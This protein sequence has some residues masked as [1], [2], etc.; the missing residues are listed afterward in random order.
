MIK[1]LNL[2]I[3]YIRLTY[4]IGSQ[5]DLANILGVKLSR[6][7]SIE[8]GKVKKLTPTE[9]DI[10]V[11]KYKISSQWILT[12]KG[13]MNLKNEWGTYNLDKANIKE[14][15]KEQIS[16]IIEL[17]QYAPNEFKDNLYARLLNFKRDATLE[18]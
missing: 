9:L 2:R 12:G 1:T 15:D 14:E 10:L 3:K 17:L 16:N 8:S 11:Q 13:T 4:K 18:I 6:V 5:Q 7:K